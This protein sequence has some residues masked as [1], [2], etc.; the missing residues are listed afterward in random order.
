MNRPKYKNHMI[1]LIDAERRFHRIQYP[2]MM[3]ILNK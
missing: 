2:F 3:E 1:S